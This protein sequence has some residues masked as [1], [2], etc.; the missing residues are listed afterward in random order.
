MRSFCT[1]KFFTSVATSSSLSFAAIAGIGAEPLKQ[2]LKS[3]A[4][5][6]GDGLIAGM[7]GAVGRNIGADIRDF[8]NRQIGRL[9]P[10]RSAEKAKR[11]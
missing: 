11:Q 1:S 4:L 5:R 8:I 2:L 10:R 3:R 9:G 6:L 7:G